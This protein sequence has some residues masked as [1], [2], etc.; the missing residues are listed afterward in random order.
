MNDLF[1][2]RRIV[3][4]ITAEEVVAWTKE[5]GLSRLFL[6]PIQRS[7]VWKNAQVINYWDSLLRG[8]PAGMM[9]VH[10]SRRMARTLEGN[11]SEAGTD[12]F[13]LFDGQQRLTAILLGHEA[14]QL[15][16][17]IKL[18]VD[19]GEPPSTD[20]GLLFQLRVNSTGQP[21]G[22]QAASPNEKPTLGQRSAKIAAWKQA[23]NLRVFVSEEAFHAVS[24]KDLIGS[25]CAFPL[26]RAISSLLANGR[27]LAIE[28][29]TRECPEALPGSI[30][31][32][33]LAL[34][35]ALKRPIIFQL[36]DQAIIE[37][38]EEYI[39]YFG[40]LGQG[41]TPLT[42]DELTYSIIKHQYPEVHDR[43]KEIMDGPAGR[44]ASEVNLV[45]AAL[46]VA[47]VCSGWD[48]GG[49]EWKIIGRPYPGFVS[50]LKQL[51]E[52]L[53]EFQKM[54]PTSR[55]GRLQELLEAIRRRLVYN[56]STNPG[57]LPVM[58]LARLPHQLVD[59]LLL[60]QNQ[61]NQKQSGPSEPDMLPPFVLHWL[62]FVS[63]SEKAAWLVFQRHREPGATGG[64][65]LIPILVQ[66]FEKA[67]IAWGLPHKAQLPLLRDEIEKGDHRLRS[68]P[69]RFAGLDADNER[70]SG[71][72][73]RA[74]SGDRERI[75]RALLWLQ[76]D[77]LAENFPDFDPT[78]TRDEDLPIDLDHLI[79]DK[80]FGFHWKSRDSF[81]QFDD[82]DENFR[83]QRGV[84]GNSLGN[85][86]WLGAS[87]NRSRGAG[88]IDIQDSD[89]GFI[90][91]ALA[92]NRL[93]EKTPWDQD[94]AASFQKLVDLRTVE[95]F[96]KLLVDGQL[97]SII[98]ESYSTPVPPEA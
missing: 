95:I 80:Q 33:V 25:Q 53:R 1:S 47:K 93:I 85:F 61:T 30:E 68:K 48:G 18:W 24:G 10:R 28:E 26:H 56:K 6:P 22:Y 79:P 36:V 75:K 11:T 15:N 54:V 40:R 94:D 3:E 46:R 17:R 70:K 59:V 27:T 29:M 98:S 12:D 78:S 4:T 74:L 20:S 2:D 67:G 43:M 21:F 19:L 82:P 62:L 88:A 90:K 39:R 50:G 7:V 44:V 42:N 16:A 97:Q 34:E 32:F 84:V 52:V 38:E 64:P 81:I 8:Y 23:R 86:R 77:Y 73:L 76:R 89:A 96:E 72:A 49:A 35:D 63:D 92:W 83:W 41:G 60:M 71:D 57:G 87:E 14:G 66:E 65:C 37:N 55:G 13:D 9:M 91:A 69:E 58:L 51:P 5:T 45:L 31:S